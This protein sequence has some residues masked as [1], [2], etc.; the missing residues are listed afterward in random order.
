VHVVQRGDAHRR[1]TNLVDYLE[2]DAPPVARPPR[3]HDRSQRA[4]DP[5]LPS[6]HLAEIFL[7]DVESQDDGVVLLDALDAHGVRLVDELTC[8]VLEELCHLLS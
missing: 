4:R 3:A 6:D 8:Q 5:A 2:L 1:A 7:R